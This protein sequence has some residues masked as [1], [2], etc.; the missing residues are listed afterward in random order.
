MTKTMVGR[1]QKKF[2]QR[3]AVYRFTRVLLMDALGIGKRTQGPA[4]LILPWLGRRA[5]G[6]GPLIGLKGIRVERVKLP[7]NVFTPAESI[8]TH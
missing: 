7:W 1:I 4:G 6:V 3:R 5:L 2:G 8:G